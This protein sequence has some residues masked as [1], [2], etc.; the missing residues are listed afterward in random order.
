MTAKLFRNSM[1]VAVS[2]MALSIALFMGVLYQYF[3]DQL[4]EEL[5]TE[6]WLVARGVELEGLNYLD[7]LETEN[8][9]TWVAADGTVLFDSSADTDAMENHN[10]RE[11]IQEAQ[12]N[13]LGTATRY[14]STLA[15]QTLYSARRLS[16]GTVIRLASSQRT[17][18]LLLLAMVPAHSGDPGPGPAAV[19]RAGL[20][21]VPEDH[22]A[23]CGAGPGASRRTAMPMT[24]WPPSS[25]GSSGR[26]TPSSSR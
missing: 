15:E 11:E 9:V 26:T 19:G 8:R 24:S 18:W 10:D 6:T 13:R 21:A 23:H 7:G 5:G 20:P 4:M 22:P 3:R 25:P 12:D 14:S 16:D 17:V 2:V 1:A